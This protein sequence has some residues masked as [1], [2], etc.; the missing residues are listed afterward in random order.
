MKSLMGHSESRKCKKGPNMVDSSES[1]SL[2]PET[3]CLQTRASHRL[4][5]KCLKA[6]AHW[7]C[8]AHLT[9]F[10]CQILNNFTK[11]LCIKANDSTLKRVLPR[12]LAQS[13]GVQHKCLC[14]PSY[15]FWKNNSSGTVELEKSSLAGGHELSALMCHESGPTCICICAVVLAGKEAWWVYGVV[16][17]IMDLCQTGHWT[18]WNA[19]PFSVSGQC[20][21]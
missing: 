8:W 21:D 17:V 11:H 3:C 6:T 1:L 4:P 18:L 20:H 7:T 15:R 19:G 12:V 9:A 5:L 2:P 10:P 13:L 16:S 14:Y